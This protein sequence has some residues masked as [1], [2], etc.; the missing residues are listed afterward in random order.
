MLEIIVIVAVVA[1]IFI[2]RQPDQF[3]VSR[4]VL[5]NAPAANIFPHI[6]DLHK[7]LPWSP[8]V[9]LDP[10]ARNTFE[11][12][13]V[14]TGAKTSWEGNNK[15]GAG[16]MTIIESR[17]SE[18]IQIQLDF[19]RPMKAT[20]IAEFTFTPQGTQT[21]VTWTMTGKS[22][23]LGKL[24]NLVMNCDKLVGKQFD[25]GLASIKGIVEAK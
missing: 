24:V 23:F 25:E 22:N 20:N 14:G 9:K 3:R 7:W 13:S 19:L 21:L 10:N 8:W 15:V 17:P 5:M 2:A 4:S 12:P 16:S 1:V 18:S 11:G 6:N